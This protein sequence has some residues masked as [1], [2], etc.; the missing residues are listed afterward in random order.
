[1]NVWKTEVSAPSHVICNG[2][3]WHQTAEKYA[4]GKKTSTPDLD[5]ERAW[6]KVL[7]REGE[8]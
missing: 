3:R 2:V 5:P 1:M 7:V 8:G 4:V 6:K